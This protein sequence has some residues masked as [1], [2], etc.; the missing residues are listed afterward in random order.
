M[1]IRPESVIR[2]LLRIEAIVAQ[3]VLNSLVMFLGG[4]ILLPIM[5]FVLWVKQWKIDAGGFFRKLFKSP[6]WLL[7]GIV[8]AIIIPFIALG[9][10]LANIKPVVEVE[11]KTRRMIGQPRKP[12]GK[13]YI[14]PTKEERER[15]DLA[16][17]VGVIKD[18]NDEAREYGQEL[19]IDE[20][21]L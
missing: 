6:L 2:T 17:T 18:F 15:Q 12:N 11:W 1:S 8:D 9:K 20:T 21:K 4:V 13:P 10:T 3:G 16:V 19:P 7:I 5:P 14:P